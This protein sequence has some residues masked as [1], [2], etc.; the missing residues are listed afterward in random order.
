VARVRDVVVALDSDTLF[1]ALYLELGAL[2]IKTP[3]YFT[4]ER[5]RR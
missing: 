2:G 3:S 4:L 1:A 5:E